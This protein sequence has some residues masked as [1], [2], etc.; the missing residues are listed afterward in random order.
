[1]ESLEFKLELTG[2]GFADRWPRCRVLVNDAVYFDDVVQGSREI[3]FNTEVEDDGENKLVIDYYNRDF[4]KDVVLGPDGMPE[5]F[6]CI[7]IENLTVDG[8]NLEHLP[9]MH[10][11]QDIY[12]PWY[13][14][15]DRE[16]FPNPRRE[17]MQISWNGRWTLEFTSP[18]YI[19]LLEN[20]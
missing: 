1:M 2:K 12:E 18:F 14:E 15:Q 8:I 17:D 3:V 19:W 7:V 9:Y 6:T 5:K 11:Y 16:E 10:S 4:R 13:L 20:L